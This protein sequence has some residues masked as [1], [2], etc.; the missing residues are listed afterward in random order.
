M[1]FMPDT[2]LPCD[3]CQGLRYGPEL[4]EV[5]WKGRS[6]GAVLQLTFEEAVPFFAFHSELSQV[7]QLMVDCG[8]GYMSR[9]VAAAKLRRWAMASAWYGKSCSSV[10]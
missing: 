8:L 5:T 2:Y 3:D 1:A 7:C 4:S 6:V 10:S 9:S